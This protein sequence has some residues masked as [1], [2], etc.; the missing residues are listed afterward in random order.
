MTLN[1]TIRQITLVVGLMISASVHSAEAGPV[2]DTKSVQAQIPFF[3][4]VERGRIREVEAFLARGFSVN[5]VQGYGFNL[6][7]SPLMKAA[8]QG[9]A[10]MVKFLLRQH[11]DVHYRNE[12]DGETALFRA[13]KFAD[14]DGVSDTHAIDYRQTLTLLLEAGANPDTPDRNGGLPLFFAR[15]TWAIQALLAGGANPDAVTTHPPLIEH[16]HD[17][18]RVRMLLAAGA[19][20]DVRDAHGVS[21]LESVAGSGSLESARQLLAVM[22]PDAVRG[23]NSDG[24]NALDAAAGHGDARIVRLLLARGLPATESAL[25]AAAADGHLQAARLLHQ[26]LGQSSWPSLDPDASAEARIYMLLLQ[27]KPAQALAAYRAFESTACGRM[28]PLASAVNAD[29]TEAVRALLALGIDVN[30][31]TPAPLRSYLS[32]QPH[33]SSGLPRLVHVLPSPCDGAPTVAGSSSQ[34]APQAT[35]P[36][37]TLPHAPILFTERALPPSGFWMGSAL[38]RAVERGNLKI[39]RLLVAAGADPTLR[40]NYPPHASAQ[41]LLTARAPSRDG[42]SAAWKALLKLNQP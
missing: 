2:H 21:A 41:A 13:A 22:A 23:T 30:Y 26:A 25:R 9:N 40:S 37:A 6:G 3:D 29:N 16:A 17:P 34:T 15:T 35:P 11:A 27:R 12:H 20:P 18:A 38:M 42:S 8:Q 39:A 31:Q 7:D 10:Q 36:V 33:T 14:T 1:G 28:T 4:A 24:H 5:D 19:N 32:P